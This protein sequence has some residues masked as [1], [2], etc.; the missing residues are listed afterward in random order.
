MWFGPRAWL[1]WGWTP[2]SWEGW[3]LCLAAVAAVVGLTVLFPEDPGLVGPVV[4]VV[5]A[6]L[7]A[8]CIL[9]GS[10]P[11]GPGPKARREFKEKQELL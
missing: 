3:V 5:V 7:A 1:G 10:S 9:K 2:V 4:L 6:V 8:A 11:G